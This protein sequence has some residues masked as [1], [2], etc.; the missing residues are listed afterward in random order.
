[1]K[2]PDYHAAR[3][4]KDMN[5]LRNST[6]ILDVNKELILNFL[7][8]AKANGAMPAT[9]RNLIWSCMT[10]ASIIS[11]P[12][13]EAT[14]DDIVKIAAE[15]E[16]R[17]KSEKTKTALKSNLKVFY[18]WLRKT[19][20]YPPEVD[21]IKINHKQVN[22]KLPEELLTEEEI[23]KMADAALNP[24][25]K[26]LVLILYESGCR[27]GEL[28]SLKIKD[29]QFDDYGC[30]L[31]VPKGKTGARRVRIIKYAKELLHWLD[32]HP[33]KNDPE[34]YVWVSLGVNTKNQ[35]VSYVG[36]EYVLRRL[37]KKVGITKKVN[38]HSFRH[39]RATHL[40]RYLPQAIMNEIFGWSKDSRMSSVYY[41]LSGKDVDEALLRMDGLKPREDKELKPVMIKTCARCGEVNSVL[42]HFCKKCNSP[43]DL[44]IMLEVDS[45]RKEFDNFIRDFLVVLAE[46]DKSIKRIFKEMVK[47]RGL[48]HLFSDKEN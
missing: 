27:I 21:W 18:R 47:E 42:A 8:F 3:L 20:D 1:M 7:E 2:D 44:K 45:R 11:K 29:V 4:P 14:Y 16:N 17:Y 28:L 9:L 33:M 34:S 31:I 15:I 26:A 30:V 22:N 35:L 5:R 6:K 48:E 24:R 43:L 40:A 38:P 39:A 36:I 37:A 19:K 10:V 41:K 46:R 12:F 13:T 32:V 23:V 25:D